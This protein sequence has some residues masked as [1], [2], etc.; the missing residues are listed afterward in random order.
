ML[1]WHPIVFCDA[2]SEEIKRLLKLQMQQTMLHCNMDQQLQF[3]FTME[4]EDQ[5][6][7]AADYEEQMQMEADEFLDAE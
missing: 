6:A 5:L 7:R 4:Q 2:T 3:N 1:K